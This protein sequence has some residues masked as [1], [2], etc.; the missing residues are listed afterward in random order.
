M[1]QN[2]YSFDD[3]DFT[4]FYGGG[5]LQSIVLFERINGLLYALIV[6]QFFDMVDKQFEVNGTWMVRVATTYDFT[7]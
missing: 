4:R 1:S 2:K 3:D 7:A 5:C 6:F